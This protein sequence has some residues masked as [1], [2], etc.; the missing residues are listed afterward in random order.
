MTR[1][2]RASALAAAAL[3]LT[4]AGCGSKAGTG[5][6]GYVDGEGVVTEV[7]V[8]DRK[9]VNAISGSTLQGDKVD[10]KT[11]AAGRPV[12]VNVWA[13]WCPPCRA[14]SAALVS[15]AKKLGDSAAFLGI[16]VRD[17]GSKDQSLAFERAKK[18]PYPS[19]YDPSGK[20]LLSFPARVSP[21]AIPSTLVIDSQGRVAASILG[22]VPSALTLVTL[23][24]DAG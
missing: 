23:V 6:K 19:L 14:E 20:S 11:Y 21:Y 3:L 16:N 13:S 17:P 8:A 5:D 15:A 18:I 2:R 4:L 1:S 9:P 24:K 10:L 12:V 22:E 7:K